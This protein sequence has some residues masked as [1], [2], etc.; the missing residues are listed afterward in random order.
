VR[1]HRNASKPKPDSATTEEALAVLDAGELR[2]LIREILPWLDESTYARLVH[3]LVDRPAQSASGFAPGGPTHDAVGEILS[4]ARAARRVGYAEPSEVDDCLRQGSNAFLGKD[5]RSAF[6]IFQAL[7]VPL[8]NADIDLGQ[9][10]TLD[11]ELFVDVAVCA[12]QYVV[13]RYRTA[14]PP[15]RGRAV[16]SAIDEV[17]GLGHFGE[18]LREM[19]RVAV[20]PLPELSEFL[21]SDPARAEVP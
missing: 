9:D 18:P 11:E 6:Q 4:F 1:A 16:L 8:G 10:E 5:Y 2:G 20:E 7:L 13:A 3:A 21:T 19:E 15:K 14:T 17:R 12:A